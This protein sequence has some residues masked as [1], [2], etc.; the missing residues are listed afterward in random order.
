MSSF[1]ACDWAFGLLLRPSI[2]I[3]IYACHAIARVRTS[4][5]GEKPFYTFSK[6]R[7]FYRKHDN[8]TSAGL[9]DANSCRSSLD[10]PQWCASLA[11][12]FFALPR[13]RDATILCWFIRRV[14]IRARVRKRVAA[15]SIFTKNKTYAAPRYPPLYINTL[16]IPPKTF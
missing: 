2:C 16:T 13:W 1:M 14:F 3:Y 8:E 11:L 9:P 7:Y 5:W 4:L 12:F 10:G 15:H 6:S